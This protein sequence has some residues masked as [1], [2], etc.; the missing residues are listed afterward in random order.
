MSDSHVEA[1]A[2]LIGADAAS[3]A[4]LPQ[5]LPQRIFLALPPDDRGRASC[6]CR[7]WHD[8]LANPSL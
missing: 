2:E 7:A 3:F 8:V 1:I 5:P 6:V 4:S